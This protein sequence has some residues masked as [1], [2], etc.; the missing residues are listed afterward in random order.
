MGTQNLIMTERVKGAVRIRIETRTRGRRAA[1]SVTE[2]AA[3]I[4][5][6]ATSIVVVDLRQGIGAKGLV[7]TMENT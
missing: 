1:E 4:T 3:T 5:A 6:M 2:M 7:W